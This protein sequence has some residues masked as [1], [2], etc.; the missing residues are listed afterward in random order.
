MELSEVE[1]MEKRQ[2]MKHEHGSDYDKDC[3]WGRR[4]W[5]A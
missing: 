5:L 3:S 2:E 1:Q 4:N